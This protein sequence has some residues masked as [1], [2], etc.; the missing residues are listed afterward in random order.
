MLEYVISKAREIPY[1]KGQQRH[2]SVIVDKRNRVVSEASNS[3][4]KTSPVMHKASKRLGLSKEY[5]HAEQ[6]AIVRSRGKGHKLYVARVDSTGK[7]VYSAPCEVCSLLL[8][9]S[10]IKSIEF[11]V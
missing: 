5:C 2:Y 11:T 6:L 8:R 9:E 7:A 1:V 3:Y 4:T 10:H